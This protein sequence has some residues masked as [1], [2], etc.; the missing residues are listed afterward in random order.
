M[1]EQ[2]CKYSKQCRNNVATLCCAKNHHCESSRVTSPLATTTATTSK[3]SLQKSKVKSGC[4]ELYRAQYSISFNSSNTVD[5]F[6]LELLSKFRKRKES[7]VLAFKSFTKREKRHFHVVVVQK[8]TKKRDARAKLL[9][10]QS[11]PIAFL[12]GRSRWRRRSCCL[13]SLLCISETPRIYRG[14]EL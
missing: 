11:K 1:L 14:V 13:S 6:F 2:C 7:R 5:N 9:F 3:T 8:C 12:P 4:L 10:C